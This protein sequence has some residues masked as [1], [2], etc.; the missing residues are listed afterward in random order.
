MGL[1]LRDEAAV[2]AASTTLTVD[3]LAELTWTNFLLANLLPVTVGN[4]IGG[5]VMVGA[6]YW[7]V[8]LRPRPSRADLPE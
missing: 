1:L 4:M 5:G 2:R 6:I 7:L 8:Y 3:A